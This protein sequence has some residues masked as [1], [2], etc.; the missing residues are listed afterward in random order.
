MSATLRELRNPFAIARRLRGIGYDRVSKV[1]VENTATRE[2]P[3]GRVIMELRRLR[4]VRL[5]S[6]ILRGRIQ[7]VG[8]FRTFTREIDLNADRK[9][10]WPARITSVHSDLCVGSS[11]HD[12]NLGGRMYAKVSGLSFY[13][14][15]EEFNP[16]DNEEN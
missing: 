9:R 1:P 6:A 10:F 13:G 16:Y 14:E 8:K 11:P 7:D 3:D 4:P 12:V 15:Q 2:T 5:K